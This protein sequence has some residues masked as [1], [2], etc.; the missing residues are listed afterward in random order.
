MSIVEKVESVEK[1]P[2]DTLFVVQDYMTEKEV[3]KLN[4]KRGHY[5]TKEPIIHIVNDPYTEMK[6]LYE[7]LSN[8]VPDKDVFSKENIIKDWAGV[9]FWYNVYNEDKYSYQGNEYEG[10]K[11]KVMEAEIIGTEDLYIDD[12]INLHKELI[13]LLTKNVQIENALDIIRPKIRKLKG[14]V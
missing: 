11:F 10:E 5:K 8:F 1:E 6:N 3:E 12:R 13:S 14:E 2:L 7:K 4:R 9:R